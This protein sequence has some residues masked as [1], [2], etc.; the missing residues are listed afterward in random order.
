MAGARV[1]A[2]A[3]KAVISRPPACKAW[4]GA[5]AA[6]QDVAAVVTDAAAK[7][8]PRLSTAGDARTAAVRDRNAKRVGG[9]DGEKRQERDGALQPL[10]AP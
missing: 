4:F 1:A 2:S 7:L 10:C 3:A 8:S 9:F 6:Q 5:F